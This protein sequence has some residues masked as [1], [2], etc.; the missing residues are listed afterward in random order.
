MVRLAGG[1]DLFGREGQPFFQ[2]EWRQILDAQP[3]RIV[4]M[5]C[6]YGLDGTRKTWNSTRV[7]HGWN[8]LR[9]VKSGHVYAVDANAYFSRP[10][11]RLAEGLRILAALLRPE[12]AR[13][14]A[15]AQ[16]ILDS[17]PLDQ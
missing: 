9:A 16:S 5:P 17:A 11:P 6:G 7:P 15:S 12:R 3:D 4:L 1:T 13:A 2:V 10:G 8:D 14:S